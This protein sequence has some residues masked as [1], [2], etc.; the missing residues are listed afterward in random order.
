MRILMVIATLLVVVNLSACH[1]MQG[2]GEDLQ[3]VGG[4]I[5]NKADK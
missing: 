1:T 5:Q 4:N 2:F 3:Q